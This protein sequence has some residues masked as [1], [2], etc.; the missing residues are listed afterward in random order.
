MLFWKTN[1]IIQWDSFLNWVYPFIVVFHLIPHHVFNFIF[2]N[3]HC[4]A[5]FTL[6]FDNSTFW[7]LGWKRGKIACMGDTSQSA[8]SQK[9]I[10][11]NFVS[12]MFSQEHVHYCYYSNHLSH[13]FK[14]KCALRVCYV[15]GSERTRHQSIRRIVTHFCFS[16]SS[17]SSKRVSPLYKVIYLYNPLLILHSWP[18]LWTQ[19]GQDI[20]LAIF[21]FFHNTLLIAGVQ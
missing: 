8:S 3:E 12:P 17:Q 6:P 9:Q 15:P 10:S 21:S 19:D 11:W 7:I 14:T 13:I 2:L 1:E 16:S 20:V 5:K 4:E 18:Q